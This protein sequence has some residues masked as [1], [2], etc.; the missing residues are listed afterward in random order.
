MQRVLVLLLVLLHLQL[1]VE[2]LILARWSKPPR[3]GS[4]RS[5]EK[6]RVYPRSVMR[7]LEMR[8]RLRCVRAGCNGRREVRGQLGRE[9]GSTGR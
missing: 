3:V 1:R 7:V 9:D 4:R 8:L 6:K 5:S 2:M